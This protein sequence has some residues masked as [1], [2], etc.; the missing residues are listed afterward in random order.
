MPGWVRPWRLVWFV[1]FYVWE[2]IVANAYVAWE[3]LTPRHHMSPGII[4][5]PVESRTA[6]EVTWLA[7]L[8]SFTPGTITVDADLER[9]VLYVHGLH[10]RDRESFVAQ[11]RS[12]ERRLLRV[13]R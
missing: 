2:V 7:N 4:G 6:I 8:V 10:V 11:I 5:V 1:A 3:V 9:G 12:L 13:L